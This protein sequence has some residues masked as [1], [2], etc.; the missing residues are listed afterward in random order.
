MGELP[1]LYRSLVWGSTGLAIVLVLVTFVLRGRVLKQAAT[2]SDAIQ[3]IAPL[4]QSHIQAFI[5]KQARTIGIVAILIAL[6]LAASGFVLPPMAQAAQH[7]GD[8]ATT[9]GAAS[10]GI[11]FL[12]GA[13]SATIVGVI[14]LLLAAEASIRSVSAAQKGYVPVVQ[15]TYGAGSIVGLLLVALV[16]VGGGAAVSASGVYASEPLLTAAL[17]GGLAALLLTTASRNAYAQATQTPESKEAKPILI[18]K[19][20]Q[21][22]E[23]AIAGFAAGIVRDSAATAAWVYTIGLL[24]LSASF[25]SGL[26]L[27]NEL[28]L[29]NKTFAIFPAIVFSIA[30]IATLI[31]NS[32]VRT[33]EERRNA[34]VSMSKGLWVSAIVGS[35]GT[36]GVFF[37]LLGQQPGGIFLLLALLVG[38]LLA[39]GLE[40]I[41]FALAPIFFNPYKRIDRSTLFA[42]MFMGRVPQI[43]A[44]GFLVVAVGVA[45]AVGG[46]LIAGST[47]ALVYSFSLTG[48]GGFLVAGVLAA[49]DMSGTIAH[50]GERLGMGIPDTSKN[51]RNTLEDLRETGAMMRGLTRGA[52]AGLAAIGTLALCGALYAALVAAV[53]VL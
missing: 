52:I 48:F 3:A 5:Q 53:P 19:A 18:S 37:F 36:V 28:E 45:I 47:A 30:A 1:S 23:T 24:L 38:V 39:G 44:I 31:G 41:I 13:L 25:M 4:L 2:A 35:I 21:A 6:A 29:D 51:A 16:A 49:M 40:R 8:A 22:D 17:G 43:W 9:W 32:M 7:F 42:G 11:G 33:S 20:G 50:Y 34:R 27:N 26:V 12:L 10:R 15:V 14:S 46:L